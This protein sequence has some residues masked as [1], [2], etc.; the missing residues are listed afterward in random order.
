[1][2]AVC[3]AAVECTLA[4]WLICKRLG[5]IRRV[6]QSVEQCCVEDSPWIVRSV[7]FIKAFNRNCRVRCQPGLNRFAEILEAAVDL[8]QV[9]NPDVSG[10]LTATKLL[11]PRL[12]QHLDSLVEG[13]A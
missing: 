7:R 13:L 4:V 12:L 11:K 3:I 9:R 10:R 8:Y 2:N 6:L 1:M 5:E